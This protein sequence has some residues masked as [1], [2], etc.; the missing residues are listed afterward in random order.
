MA[1]V[2]DLILTLVD[3]GEPDW[4]ELRAKSEAELSEVVT[5]SRADL[6]QFGF[7]GGAAD[8]SSLLREAVHAITRISRDAIPRHA[9][10]ILADSQE[11]E[12]NEVFAAFAAI[13]LLG[14]PT[15]QASGGE[16]ATGDLVSPSAELRL[17]AMLVFPFRFSDPAV[18]VQANLLIA[19]LGLLVAIAAAL[20]AYE[21]TNVPDWLSLHLGLP[22]AAVGVAGAYASQHQH[23]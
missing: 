18:L 13:L 10:K 23:G 1:T 17:S 12:L 22:L 19:W 4:A 6:E 5:Q 9:Q 20:D 7:T 11:R 2:R 15:V 16:V 14:R 8:L 3:E 21:V